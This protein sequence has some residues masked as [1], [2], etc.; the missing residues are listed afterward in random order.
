[1]YPGMP[2]PPQYQPPVPEGQDAAQYQ[3][4]G[5]EMHAPPQGPYQAGFQ[6]PP[7]G[8]YAPYSAPGQP[9]PP[10]PG[11]GYPPPPDYYRPVAPAYQPAYYPPPAYAP[12]PRW[13]AAQPEEPGRA[14]AIVSLVFAT[15]GIGG[16][17]LGCCWL[18]CWGVV[19]MLLCSLTAFIVGW[20]SLS[21]AVTPDVEANARLGRALGFIGV[22]AAILFIILI[23]VPYVHDLIA[24]P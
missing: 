6:A 19:A 17:V 23:Q 9:V 3:P 22:V 8:P 5:P 10:G 1:M 11:Y 21:S 18:Q 2:M 13:A 4:P 20:L 14:A 7:R 12:P 24:L 16:H 15:I